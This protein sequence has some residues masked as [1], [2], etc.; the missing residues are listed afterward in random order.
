M[1]ATEEPTK[2]FL[3]QKKEL[4]DMLIWAYTQGYKHAATV[5]AQTEPTD[6]MLRDMFAKHMMET[7]TGG[8]TKD[9]LQT[10]GHARSPPHV[11][12]PT[13]HGFIAAGGDECERHGLF[14]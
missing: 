5:V 14:T 3:E 8:E 7:Q 10:A 12:G 11:A 6:V 4:L 2:D 1:N 13:V 9:A